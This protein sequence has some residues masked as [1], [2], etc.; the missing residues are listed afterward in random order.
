LRGRLTWR[1][2]DPTIAAVDSSG[3]VRGIAPGNATITASVTYSDGSSESGSVVV[4]VKQNPIA[5]S[6]VTRRHRRH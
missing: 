3:N 6:S 1:T 5:D 2:A 4:I